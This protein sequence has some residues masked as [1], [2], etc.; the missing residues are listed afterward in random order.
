MANIRPDKLILRCYGRRL[1][2]GSYYGVCIDL[3]L[4]VEAESQE[5]LKKKM[6]DV[7]NS[8]LETVLDTDDKNSIPQLLYRRAPIQ[9]W[10][11]YY[12]IRIL[13]FIKQFPNNFT[14]QEYIPFH[15]AHN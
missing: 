12:Y 2:K 1:K 9:D 10:L 7:I 14:F 8:Y 5:K 4:A 11:R 15:L 6:C 3:N 13:V